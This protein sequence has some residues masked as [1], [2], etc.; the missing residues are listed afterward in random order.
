MVDAPTRIPETSREVFRL[1][2]RELLDDLLC[3]ELRSQ[4]IE[5]VH[6]ADPGSTDARATAALLRIDCDAIRYL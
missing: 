1:A 3:S 6:H 2:I 5:D 4:E